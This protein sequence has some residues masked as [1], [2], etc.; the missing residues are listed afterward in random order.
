[1]KAWNF[2]GYG[3]PLERVELPEPRPGPCE[4]L[5]DIKA[6]GLCHSDIGIASGELKPYPHTI[7]VVLG[8]EIAGIISQIGEAVTEFAVGDRVG[9]YQLCDGHGDIRNG[10]YA[11][12]TTATTDALVPIPD[13]TTFAQAAIGTDAGMT[14]HHA[15]MSVGR[16]RKGT[17]LGIIGLGGLGTIGARIGVIAGAT[18]Y[19]AEPQQVAHRRG[20]EAGVTAV[21][22]D[23]TEFRGLDLDVIVDFAGFGTTTAGAIDVIRPGGRVVQV[24]LGVAEATINTLVLSQKQVELVGSFG[25]DKNDIAA[26]YELFASGQ[27]SS[28]ISAITL[29]DVPEGLDLLDSGTAVGRIVVE[30]A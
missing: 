2:V 17:K 23:V 22:H 18:V 20:H 10:G 27:L 26:V 21:F 13:A 12:F 6:A 4:V 19:A 30:R 5:I 1:M 28:P 3:R 15:V 9:V 25:G 16:T 7:P 24:G 29:D 14:S 8:H 11:E